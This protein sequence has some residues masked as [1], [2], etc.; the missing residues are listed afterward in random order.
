MLFNFKS[1]TGRSKEKDNEKSL[2]VTDFALVIRYY[3]FT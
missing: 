2:L 1:G 3:F